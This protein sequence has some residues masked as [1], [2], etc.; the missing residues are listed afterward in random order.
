MKDL[1]ICWR[2]KKDF[3]AISKSNSFISNGR[4]IIVIGKDCDGKDLKVRNGLDKHG[5]PKY[6]TAYTAY[7]Y[8]TKVQLKY[9]HDKKHLIESLSDKDLTCL[10]HNGSLF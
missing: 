6:K 10:G 4:V 7:D 5:K 8:E 3:P 1:D 2:Y 9:H